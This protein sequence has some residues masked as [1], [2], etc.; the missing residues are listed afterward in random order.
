M[1]EWVAVM[2]EG[3]SKAHSPPAPAFPQHED[4]ERSHEQFR[5]LHGPYER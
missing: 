1:T 3:E 2:D 5:Y 4:R